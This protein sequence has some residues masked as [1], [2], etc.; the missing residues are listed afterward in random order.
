MHLFSY[1]VSH[2]LYI[3]LEHFDINQDNFK[4]TMCNLNFLKYLSS[5]KHVCITV[6][7]THILH[8]VDLFLR[9]WSSKFI[10]IFL[11]DFLDF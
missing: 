3:E 11:I 10:L 5:Y 9:Q 7:M 1:S 6:Y 8:Y 2:F 4:S